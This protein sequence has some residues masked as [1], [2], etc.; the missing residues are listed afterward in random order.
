[1]LGVLRLQSGDGHDL[2]PNVSVG[3]DWN[4]HSG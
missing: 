1:L 4:W 3:D 2:D